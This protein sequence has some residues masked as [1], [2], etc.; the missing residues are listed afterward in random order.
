[1]MNYIKSEFYRVFHG[2]VIY[3]FAGILAALS[4]LLN[5]V[6]MWFGRM[7]GPGFPYDT[8]SFSYSN[9]AANPMLFCAM[10]A[11]TGMLLYEGGRKNGNLKNPIAFGISRVKIFAGE[12]LVAAVSAVFAL[13]I[14]LSF[15]ILSAVIMLEQTGPVSL[16]DLMTEVPAVFFISIA[17]LISGIVCI[18]AFEKESVGIIL[19]SVIWFVIPKVFFY[20]GLRYPLL[21]KIAMWMPDNFFGT[22]GM[23]VNMGKSITAWGTPEGMLKCV[24]AGVIGTVIFSLLG[25]ALLRKKELS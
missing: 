9:L 6:L 25:V 19:W 23:T 11:L 13:V 4:L 20:L 1:M 3:A 18:E 14:V 10:A 15:Y 5:I 24:I 17:S 22:S 8:T 16:T 21:Y 2:C 12:C 7:Y